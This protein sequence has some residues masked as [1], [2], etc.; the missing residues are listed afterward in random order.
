MD[1]ICP[2]L[3]VFTPNPRVS[4]HNLDSRVGQVISTLRLGPEPLPTSGQQAQCALRESSI[5]IH[6]KD[7]EGKAGAGWGEREGGEGEGA[8]GRGEG[9]G[10][11]GRLRNVKMKAERKIRGG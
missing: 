8:E 10:G 5:S 6:H 4:E 1:I 3:G 9:G 11:E 7:A 2:S